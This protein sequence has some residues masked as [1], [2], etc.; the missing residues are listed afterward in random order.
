MYFK[1][2]ATARL[3]S[4]VNNRAEVSSEKPLTKTFLRE[5]HCLSVSPSVCLYSFFN[6]SRALQL[7]G[8][9]EQPRP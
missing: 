5:R 6:D 1:G 8:R 7:A 3:C 9:E 2:E 4:L